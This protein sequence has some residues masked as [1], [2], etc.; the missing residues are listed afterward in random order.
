MN[1][2]GAPPIHVTGPDGPWEAVSAALERRGSV[3]VY[4]TWG[5]G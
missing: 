5:S 3:V 1:R 4:A 2:A